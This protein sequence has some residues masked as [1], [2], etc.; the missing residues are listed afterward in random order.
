M[1]TVE[2]SFEKARTLKVYSAPDEEA[3]AAERAQVTTDHTVAIYGRES[4]WV[5]VSYA[6][7]D[8]SRGRTGYIDDMTL[9]DPS[10]VPLLDFF[11]MPLPLVRNAK[12]TDDPLRSQSTITTLQK[13]SEVTLLAFFGDDWAYVET[14]HEEKICRLFIPASALKED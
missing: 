14:T 4:G 9:A 3:W 12:A 7:G 2:A 6:I 10:S 5:L 8:G 1:G 13:G 11:H